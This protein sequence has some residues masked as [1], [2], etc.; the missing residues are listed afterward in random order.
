MLSRPSHPSFPSRRIGWRARFLDSRL[1][2]SVS[3]VFLGAVVGHPEMVHEDA[4]QGRGLLGSREACRG[5]CGGEE[6][7]GAQHSREEAG[8]AFVGRMLPPSLLLIPHSVRDCCLIIVI[9]MGS[10]DGLGW[11]RVETLLCGAL[12]C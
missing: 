5:G 6:E 4:G 10:L 3:W 2:L 11:L 8:A 1:S 12:C 9:I 7:A